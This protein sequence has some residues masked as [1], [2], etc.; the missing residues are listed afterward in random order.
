MRTVHKKSKLTQL[1]QCSFLCAKTHQVALLDNCVHVQRRLHSW[2]SLIHIALSAWPRLNKLCYL[3]HDANESRLG[4]IKRLIVTNY[5]KLDSGIFRWACHLS[6]STGFFPVVLSVELRFENFISR[7][8]FVRAC[9]VSPIK[10]SNF[11]WNHDWTSA[12][13]WNLN[14]DPLQTPKTQLRLREIWLKHIFICRP[15]TTCSNRQTR[16][17]LFARHCKFMCVCLDNLQWMCIT[18]FKWA[19]WKK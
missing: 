3:S 9:R 2:I 18:C 1:S 19:C 5:R 17:F 7:K 8:S 13:D 4:L 14:S 6:N 16:V 10:R 11:S 15:F 12:I